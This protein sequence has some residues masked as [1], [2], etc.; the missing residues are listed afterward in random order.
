[1]SSLC[2]PLENNG[3]IESRPVRL[4]NRLCPAMLCKSLIAASA[5]VSTLD[6]QAY[7]QIQAI[8]NRP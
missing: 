8:A 4:I 7:A 3:M 1:M 2:L 5:F 6:V